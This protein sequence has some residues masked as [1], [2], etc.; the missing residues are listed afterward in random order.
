VERCLAREA[1]AVGTLERMLP[2][3]YNGIRSVRQ[4]SAKQ[5]QSQFSIES[6][7]FGELARDFLT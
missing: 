2:V 3:R 7:A 4:L 1:E 5:G 6:A